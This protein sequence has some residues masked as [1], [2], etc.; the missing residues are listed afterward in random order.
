VLHV[1][2]ATAQGTV[3]IEG[4]TFADV[5]QALCADTV[6]VTAE[7]IVEEDALRRS[8]ERL[9]LI[10]ADST[11]PSTYDA[12]LT[13]RLA[14]EGPDWAHRLAAGLLFIA[15]ESAGKLVMVVVQPPR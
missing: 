5:Q 8:P 14:L 10:E 15:W 3:R 9:R 1:Q 6:I 11:R 12:G 4:Q 13:L 2:K 7:E